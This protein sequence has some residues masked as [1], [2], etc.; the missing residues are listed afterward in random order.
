MHFT[1]S[2]GNL[3]SDGAA[4]HLSTKKEFSVLPAFLRRFRTS[5]DALLTFAQPALWDI[6]KNDIASTKTVRI[7][8][9]CR[10]TKMNGVFHRWPSDRGTSFATKLIAVRQRRISEDSP[11]ISL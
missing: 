4:T 10:T 2:D 8:T 11:N 7:V 9:A 5:C 3:S 1:N 6:Q